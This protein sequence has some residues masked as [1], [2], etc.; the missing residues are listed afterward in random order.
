MLPEQ[1]LTTLLES[2]VFDVSTKFI[3]RASTHNQALLINLLNTIGKLSSDTNEDTVLPVNLIGGTP[4]DSPFS[5]LQQQWQEALS[6]PVVRKNGLDE[7]TKEIIH[8]AIA[9]NQR[10]IEA[11]LQHMRTMGFL[12]ARAK[13]AAHA[14]PFQARL[15]SHYRT[16]QEHYISY[17]TQ[18][19]AFQKRKLNL[20]SQ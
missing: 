14:T 8:K 16:I 3:N 10:Q 6:K 17:L 4:I 15:L 2:Y 9:V 18:L 20:L 5:D 11:T 13:D 7:A 1:P 12:I 19:K